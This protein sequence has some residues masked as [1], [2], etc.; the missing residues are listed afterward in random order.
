[1]SGGERH[2]LFVS[3]PTGYELTE[4]AGEPPAPGTELSLDEDGRHVVTKIASSPMPG[5]ER[6]CAYL[7]PLRR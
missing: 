3:K 6:R 1:M 2:L 7:Q 5:D 4:R